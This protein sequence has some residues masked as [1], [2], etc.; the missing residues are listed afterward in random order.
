MGGRSELVW[1][2]G[3]SIFKG[4]WPLRVAAILLLLIQLRLVF[5]TG[6]GDHV[7]SEFVEVKVG[8]LGSSSKQGLLPNG[9]KFG[10]AC[11]ALGLGLVAW[12]IFEN[13]GASKGAT[14]CN[15]TS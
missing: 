3:R 6:R 13:W 8:L 1:P 10:G 9:D 4:P 11:L 14:Q 15:L 12:A 2:A 7:G 5:I